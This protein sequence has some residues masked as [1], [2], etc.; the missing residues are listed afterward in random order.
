MRRWIKWYGIDWLNST[1]RDELTPA[2]RATFVDFVCLAS[3]PGGL[4][5]TFKVSSWAALARKLN[6]PLAVVGN[7]LKKCEMTRISISKNAEGLLVTVL[8]WNKYQSPLRGDNTPDADGVINNATKCSFFDNES[9]PQRRGEEI[10]GEEIRGKLEGEDI[11][12]NVSASLLKLWNS[13]KII[14]HQRVTP[15]MEK[16]ILGALQVYSEADIR[17]AMQNYA[18]IVLG[19]GYYFKFKWTLADF[20]SRRKADNIERFLDL[21]VAK[22][23]YKEKGGTDDT[24]KSRSIPGNRPAGAF[25]DLEP[26][27]D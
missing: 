24:G 1:A 14:Q 6:T 8:N 21:E 9:L 15:S 3:F 13:L 22:V 4:P 17:Q 26:E 11:K 19:N 7:T 27:A 10:R 25:A 2:E 5:G 16:A 12:E 18:E 23:N 20:L